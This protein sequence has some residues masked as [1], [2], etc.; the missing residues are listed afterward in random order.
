[1][2]PPRDND[3]FIGPGL[4]LAGFDVMVVYQYNGSYPLRGSTTVR[5]YPILDG[6]QSCIQWVIDMLAGKPVRVYVVCVYITQISIE[7]LSERS[8]ID[9]IFP[10][11]DEGVLILHEM[12]RRKELDPKISTALLRSLGVAQLSSSRSLPVP[13]LSKLEWVK[14]AESIHTTQSVVQI[15]TYSIVVS[16][17][18]LLCALLISHA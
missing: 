1:M 13:F 12:Q 14:V 6:L 17:L 10:A 3:H 16:R 15:P 8:R 2:V 4:A 7:I 5:V 9:Y 18:Y 11:D